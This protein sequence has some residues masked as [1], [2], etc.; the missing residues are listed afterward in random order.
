[1]ATRNPPGGSL[2]TLSVLGRVLEIECGDEGPQQASTGDADEFLALL[3]DDITIEVQKLRPDLY[4]VHA[5]AV[6]RRGKALLLVA[7]AGGGKSTTTWALLHHGFRYLSDELAPVDLESMTVQPFPRALCLKSPPPEPYEL[8]EP[9]PGGSRV[10]HV[11][12]GSLPAEV[13]SDSVPLGALVFVEI[14]SGGAD[15]RLRGLRPARAAQLLYAHALNPLAHIDD[16]LA[17][18]LRIAER[19]PCF[20]LTATDLQRTSALLGNTMDELD[21]PG[22]G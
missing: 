2:L 1:M 12:V 16:G 4:F 3:N 10:T 6:E 13:V 18:A 15:P 5:A 22:S 19:V 8:P 20:E 14:D 11:P 21:Q 9:I 7:E 17:G